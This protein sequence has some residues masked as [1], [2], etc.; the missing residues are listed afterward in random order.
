MKVNGYEIPE[1]LIFV[2]YMG[3]W[4]YLDQLRMYSSCR[5]YGLIDS[6]NLDD[7]DESRLLQWELEGKIKI[8][9]NEPI[10]GLIIKKFEIQR[11]L[12]NDPR[13]EN[14]EVR[15]PKSEFFSF[16]LNND[17]AVKSR[18]IITDL[19]YGYNEHGVG[20]ISYDKYVI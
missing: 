13:I 1:N 3:G 20:F 4:R 8:I 10:N 15:I 14:S 18:Q 11:V 19:I 7:P 16:I 17:F 9:K 2:N 6:S 12:I 5:Y